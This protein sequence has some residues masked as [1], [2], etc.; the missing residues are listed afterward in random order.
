[1]P[2]APILQFTLEAQRLVIPILVRRPLPNTEALIA[3]QLP[4]VAIEKGQLLPALR[5]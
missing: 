4:P 5:Q 1:V 3:L 2:S